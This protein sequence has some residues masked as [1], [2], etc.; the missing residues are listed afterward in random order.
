[1]SYNWIKEGA[2]YRI[3]G[4]ECGHKFQIGDV[5]WWTGEENLFTNGCEGWY[6]EDVEVELVKNNTLT[7]G[8][9]YISKNGHKWLC[10]AVDG[11]YAHMRQADVPASAAY[12]FKTDGTN[13]SQGGGEWDIKFEPVVEWVDTRFSVSTRNTS[14]KDGGDN[15][16]AQIRFPL[17]DGKPDWS[18]AKLT[19]V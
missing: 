6:L 11:E 15:H 3:I 10:I 18:S 1:M 12:C 9:T 2:K 7:V 14:R 8:E 5:V 19:G 16:I 13:I 4:R 17:I